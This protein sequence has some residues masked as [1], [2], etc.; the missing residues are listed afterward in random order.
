[1]REEIFK[2]L[3][4]FNL[5]QNQAKV[6]AYLCEVGK[7]NATEISHNTQ[8][9]PQDIYKSVTVLEKKG[10]VMRTN[11][12]P[13]II[14][15]IPVKEGLKALMQLFE[16]DSKEKL[17]KL[18]NYYKEIEKGI[19]VK[20][21]AK[22]EYSIA[23][24]SKEAPQSRVDLAFNN[25]RKEY[26]CVMTNESWKQTAHSSNYGSGPLLF[27]KIVKKGAFIKFLFINK[28]KM[29]TPL[30]LIKKMMP[31]NNF[32]IRSL[33]LKDSICPFALIDNREVWLTLPSIG[34]EGTMILTDA[35]EMV[36]ITRRQFQALWNDPNSKI[37]LQPQLAKMKTINSK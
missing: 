5:S 34:T 28:E 2:K 3:C 35:K 18:R 23:V 21:T 9:H 37:E 31:K 11:S 14:E 33:Q 13:L 32:E 1:M 10:L 29:F 20:K 30:E 15:A 19:K 36:E 22:Q 27:K 8:I 17:R 26:D 16:N 4:E 25:L 24:F 6:Y 12:K 7:A